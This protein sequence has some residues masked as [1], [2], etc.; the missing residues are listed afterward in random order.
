MDKKFLYNIFNQKL[1][2]NATE[3]P[4]SEEN[5]SAY[6][7]NYNFAVLFNFGDNDFASSIE[8]GAEL[9]CDEFNRIFE[10]IS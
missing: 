8:C 4:S 2:D 10:Q 3:S 7:K 1:V 9:F 5:F 6:R